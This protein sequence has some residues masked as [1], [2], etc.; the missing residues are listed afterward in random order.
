MKAS[1]WARITKG[2]IG[3]TL[4]LLEMEATIVLARGYDR[5]D[6]R[7]RLAAAHLDEDERED[8]GDHQENQDSISDYAFHR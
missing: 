2:E 1:S 8:G 5:V 3:S 6:L 4:P 7:D